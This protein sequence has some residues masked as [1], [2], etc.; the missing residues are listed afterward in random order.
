MYTHCRFRRALAALY[1]IN[2]RDLWLP[3]VD[4]VYVMYNMDSLYHYCSHLFLFQFYV[5]YR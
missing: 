5:T 2:K 1:I 4:N 3:T